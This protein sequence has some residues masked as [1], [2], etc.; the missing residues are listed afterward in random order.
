MAAQHNIVAALQKVPLFADLSPTQ[1]K[2]VLIICKQ[3]C[4]EPG[5]RLCTLGADSDRMFVL[6]SGSVDILSASGA[7][8]VHEEAIT[9]IG[10]AGVLTGEARSATVIAASEVS[11]MAISRRSF[12]Q[13][14]QED[15]SLAVRLYRNV[16]M[17]LR[18]KLVVS[19]RRI[20]ELLQAEELEDGEDTDD[21]GDL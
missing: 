6:L 1:L 15:P 11:A 12:V 7:T 3:E 4:H 17:I 16:M 18:Q 21:T 13:L 5:T 14:V 19:N 10:E 8:L 20:D 9:T 2:R